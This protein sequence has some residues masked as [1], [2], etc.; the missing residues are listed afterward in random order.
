MQYD[1]NKTNQFPI[2]K[3]HGGYFTDWTPSG[4]TTSN[5]K[6]RM[7]LPT[8]NNLFRSTLQSNAVE[9]ANQQNIAFV[10]KTSKLANNGEQI[11]CTTDTDCSTGFTCNKQHMTWNDVKG[12]QGNYCSDTKYPEL[13]GGVYNRKSRFEGGITKKCNSNSDC[14]P[15]YSC[16]NQVDIF[17]RGSQIGYCAQTYQCQDGVKYLQYPHGA[18]IPFEPPKDQNNGGAGYSTINDCN[19]KKLPYQHC[20]KDINGRWFAVYPGYCPPVT[21]LRKNDNPMGE[22]MQ[23]PQAVVNQGIVL[24]GFGFSS[25]SQM[26]SSVGDMASLS[27]VAPFES[28]SSQTFSNIGSQLGGNGVS[29]AMAYELYIN[30]R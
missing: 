27:Q 17:G 15:G 2:L 19:D 11:S 10:N 14:A 20:A 13:E 4:Q 21:D 3:Q 7:N 8:D 25:S 23:T 29:E 9:I 24:P 18:G 6:R 12:N 5:L 22:L 30:P 28:M 16:N 1:N 26:G